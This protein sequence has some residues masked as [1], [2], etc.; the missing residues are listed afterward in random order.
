MV[1]I[2]ASHEVLGMHLA[3][4][5]WEAIWWK[6]HAVLWYPLSSGGQP[7]HSPV[8][9]PACCPYGCFLCRYIA[10]S[11]CAAEPPREGRAPVI[12]PMDQNV[13]CS[14]TMLATPSENSTQP[15]QRTKAPIVEWPGCSMPTVTQSLDKCRTGVLGV[16]PTT[17]DLLNH[18]NTDW[19]PETCIEVLGDL[20]RTL[21]SENHCFS[22]MSIAHSP[23]FW[24]G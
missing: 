13:E 4:Q 24:Q 2:T 7:L 15:C 6:Q 17:T 5:A 1:N 11:A 22:A 18:A 14:I 3:H 21:K 20:P 23:N 16:G 8:L 19:D 12:G 9:N 10:W